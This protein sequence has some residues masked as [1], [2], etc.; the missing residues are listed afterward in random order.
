MLAIC[1]TGTAGPGRHIDSVHSR[2]SCALEPSE[3]KRVYL[4]LHQ[5]ISQ[6]YDVNRDR[7]LDA[8]DEGCKS[9]VSCGFIRCP[10]I[11]HI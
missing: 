3:W 4:P 7:F 8:E 9:N 6:A 1:S 5:S 2:T 10:R 11:A